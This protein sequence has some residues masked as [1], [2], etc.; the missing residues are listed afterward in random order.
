[1]GY[2]SQAASV[3]RRQVT[4]TVVDALK[5][6]AAPSAA[7]VVRNIAVSVRKDEV[8]TDRMFATWEDNIDEYT[9]LS[10][11][12]SRRRQRLISLE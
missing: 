4:S 7:L 3:D 5:Q 1:M 6:S 10:D 8:A 9:R 11:T 12:S 2:E